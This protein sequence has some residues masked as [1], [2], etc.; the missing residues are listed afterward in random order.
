MLEETPSQ[1]MDEE[2]RCRFGEIASELFVGDFG[3][4]GDREA[5]AGEDFAVVKECRVEVLE[6]DAG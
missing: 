1:S 4:F 2:L 5:H 6:C 3:G